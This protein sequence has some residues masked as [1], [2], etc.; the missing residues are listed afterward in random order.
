MKSFWS[1]L[2]WRVDFL[3]QMAPCIGISRALSVCLAEDWNKLARILRPRWCIREVHVRPKGYDASV[4]IRMGTSDFTV[5]Q[6][7][8][9]WEQYRPISRIEDPAVIVDC[10]A[11]AGYASVF[12]LKQFP[13]ARVIAVEPDPLNAEV[14]RRN[15]RYNADR[16]LVLQKAVWGSVTTLGFVD[17]TRRAGEEWAIQVRPARA[18][19]GAETV[20]AIDIPTLMAMAGV[21]QIDLLKIDIEGSEADIFQ[22]NPAAWLDRVRNI[23]IELHGPVC[24]EIFDSALEGYSFL[25]AKRGEVTFCLGIHPN[26]K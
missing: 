10:G 21:K 2:Q 18:G 1:A 20:K 24:S 26:G 19:D 4:A 16:V 15:T 8:F 22:S 7:V 3:R 11:N 5:F 23:E 25:K 12:F 6:Q 9:L 17:Q 13:R 14:C